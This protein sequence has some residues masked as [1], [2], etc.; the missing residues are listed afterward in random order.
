MCKTEKSLVL[1]PN[2]EERV[3]PFMWIV[4]II[5][6]SGGRILTG[7]SG[8]K[9]LYI[10][11]YS[12]TGAHR[13]RGKTGHSKTGSGVFPFSDYIYKTFLT[14]ALFPIHFTK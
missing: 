4:L 14:F 5:E 13:D 9:T 8:Y 12:L 2:L 7:F 6:R 3:I 1:R 11:F 10:M